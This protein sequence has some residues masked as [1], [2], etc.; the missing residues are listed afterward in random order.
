VPNA[1][2][3][4][5]KKAVLLAYPNEGHHLEFLQAEPEH[6]LK[7]PVLV[8]GEPLQLLDLADGIG[9][10]N[11]AGEGPGLGAGLVLPGFVENLQFAVSRATE[12]IDDS[13][14]RRDVP[15]VCRLTFP[16]SRGGWRTPLRDAERRQASSPDF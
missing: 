3:Y 2:R 14:G 8:L 10:H 13:P 15:S 5:G 1:L 12:P 9:L 11:V 7:G 4:N 16:G 6:V